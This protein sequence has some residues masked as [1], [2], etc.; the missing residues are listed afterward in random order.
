MGQLSL[1][2]F[3]QKENHDSN[4][5]VPSSSLQLSERE[6]MQDGGSLREETKSG[7]GEAIVSVDASTRNLA[8]SVMDWQVYGCVDPW[9]MCALHQLRM[10]LYRPVMHAV[11]SSRRILSPRHVVRPT[12]EPYHRATYQCMEVDTLGELFVAGDDAGVVTVGHVEAMLQTREAEDCVPLETALGIGLS[13]K[14]ASARWNTSNQNEIGV[15]QNK[16]RVLYVFDINRTQGDPS[17]T[18]KLASGG[19]SLA[20]FDQSATM[21]Q[22][23]CIAVG[24]SDGTVALCDSRTGSQPVCMLRSMTG[25]AITCLQMMDHGRLVLG[26]THHDTIKIWDLRRVSGNAVNFGAVTN[27]HPILHTVQMMN[28]LAMI[29]GLIDESGYIPSCTPQS[30]HQDPNVYSRVAVHMSCGWTTVLDVARLGMTHIHAPPVARTT[31]QQGESLM[32]LDDAVNARLIGDSGRVALPH[33]IMGMQMNEN[34]RRLADRASKVSGCWL[35]GSQF[36]IP[37]RSKNAVFII[38]FGTHSGTR[39]G[40]TRDDL[41]TSAVPIDIPVEPTCVSGVLHNGQ[42]SLLAFGRRGH[43]T[44]LQV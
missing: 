1:T 42:E 26:G 11:Y 35:E 18:I 41:R 31:P 29:P 3:L 22:N 7:G 12:Y 17:R 23:Y 44:V 21:G 28:E 38:D 5:D 13:S 19:D 9:S 34:E 15:L 27:K 4:D 6:Q 14:I 39:I 20:F 10:G 8:R 33:E 24:C 2:S 16:G 30:L 25:G 32:T 40:Y 37:S 36:V 43:C